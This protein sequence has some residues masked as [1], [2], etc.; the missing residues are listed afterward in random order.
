M[1]T[2]ALVGACSPTVWWAVQITPPVHLSVALGQQVLWALSVELIVPL[3]ANQFWVQSCQGAA[4]AGIPASTY[5]TSL[6][7]L[8]PGRHFGLPSMIMAA[9]F[10]SAH[11]PDFAV[12]TA[13]DL[14]R[15]QSTIALGMPLSCKPWVALCQHGMP[16][17]ATRMS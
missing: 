10:I 12:R 7:K 3:A 16:C 1:L 6:A 17:T 5:R 13:G 14:V 8:D 2:D 11:P 9:V 4:D 15:G